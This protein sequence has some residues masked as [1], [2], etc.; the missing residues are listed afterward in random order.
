MNSECLGPTLICLA[1]TEKRILPLNSSWTSIWSR[2]RGC[3]CTIYDLFNFQPSGGSYVKLR[4]GLWWVRY[5]AWWSEGRCSQVIAQLV[6]DVL[7]QLLLGS[8]QR[9]SLLQSS[10]WKGPR[11]SMPLLSPCGFYTSLSFQPSWGVQAF[12]WS[13]S[14]DRSSPLFPVPQLSSMPSSV[15]VTL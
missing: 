4:W 1:K 9:P 3:S 12:H 2:C 14:R 11:R 10:I 5:M 15:G 7:F 13:C 6:F 8:L